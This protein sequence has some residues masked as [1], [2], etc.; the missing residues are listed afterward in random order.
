[1][2]STQVQKIDLPKNTEFVF[3]SFSKPFGV[4]N[5]RTGWIFTRQPDTRLQ[6]LTHSAKYYNYYANSV[7]EAIIAN[8]DID[9]VYQQLRFTQELVC[10][11]YGFEPSDSVWLAQTTDKRYEKFVRNKVARLCLAPCY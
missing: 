8:F 3:Y 5:I 7:S 10:A 6:A 9:Y 4:R 2:G 11:R 1:M